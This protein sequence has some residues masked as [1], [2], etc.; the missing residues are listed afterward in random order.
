M[1]P[2]RAGLALR[3]D[4]PRATAAALLAAV[5]IAALVLRAWLAVA[6]PLADTTESRY[7][8][9]ARQMAQ[10]GDW[11]VPRLSPT[12]PFMAKPPLSTWASAGAVRLLG[13]SE[14]ALRAGSL[15]AALLA[16]WV[17]CRVEPHRD[18]A[19]RATAAAVLC[20]APVWFVSAGAVMTDMWH[21]LLVAA[22]LAAAWR[23]IQDDAAPSWRVAFWGALGAGLLAK[24][25]ATVALAAMPIAA[26]A[27]L[28]RQV[29]PVVAR[30][31]S[32]AGIALALAVAL[33]WYLAMERAQPGFSR[34]FFVGE[35]LQRYLQPGWAGDR[36]G[37]AHLRPRGASWAFLA[38]GVLPWLPLAGVAAARAWRAR[39]PG[40]P[41]PRTLWLLA[42][43]LVAPAF[44]TLTRN[45]LW[46][47][48][49][50]SVAPL[51]L[52]LA[53]RVSADATLRRPALATAALSVALGTAGTLALAPSLEQRSQR[54]IVAAWDAQRVAR[55]GPLVYEA[56]AP[57]SAAF[58]AR[59]GYELA[60]ADGLRG[61]LRRPGA[62]VA[63]RPD[64]PVG[65]AGLPAGCCQTLA[66][67]G[68]FVLLRVGDAP[69]PAAGG[70]PR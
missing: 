51:A 22:A 4:A 18:A 19:S 50:T 62:Y 35:H 10:T 27:L 44:F 29:R 67:A 28:A 48:A 55:P 26:Y 47:Y 12:E 64:G 40:R 54:A 69:A 34:Y 9:V 6:A 70:A 58:Y 61:W 17:A 52:W 31:W 68:D 37:T 53:E 30:L 66:R 49:L 15:V 5:A 3:T 16:L 14:G 59:R 43:V 25:L 39:R 20:T 63:L 32:P 38:L 60:S 65:I 24:G 8:E 2:L 41:A 57:D 45:T 23:A 46:T 11:V 56:P 7:G 13:L 33:P 21:A 42:C 1:N 36:F